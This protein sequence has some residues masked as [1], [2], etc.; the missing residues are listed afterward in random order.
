MVLRNALGDF[1]VCYIKD[2][3]QLCLTE[4]GGVALVGVR[5]E[6][7]SALGRGGGDAEKQFTYEW[8]KANKQ[9]YSRGL[10][11]APHLEKSNAVLQRFLG[12][13]LMAG[14]NGVCQARDRE[15][16]GEEGRKR[17]RFPSMSPP[18]AAR[19]SEGDY[20]PCRGSRYPS[21]EEESYRGDSLNTPQ[22]MGG[23]RDGRYDYHPPARGKH[24]RRPPQWLPCDNGWEQEH[25]SYNSHGGY[26]KR[27]PYPR[28]EA[29]LMTQAHQAPGVSP[30]P[31]AYCGAPF[32]EFRYQGD[33][34]APPYAATMPPQGV[35]IP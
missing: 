31:T 4:D 19:P 24:P 2:E 29:Y 11:R 16:A 3:G 14:P 8:S 13:D 27:F 9:L 21:P 26:G 33:G 35:N 22:P 25:R 1:C 10:L 32:V 28:P 7:T 5:P 17:R 20:T 34:R 18:G 12:G 6:A 15:G 23:L 30:A